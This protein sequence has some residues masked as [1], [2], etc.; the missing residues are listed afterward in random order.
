[1][2]FDDDI[3]DLILLKNSA[4]IA[5]IFE[6]IDGLWL[7]MGTG[8]GRTARSI[9]RFLPKDKKLYTF[10]CFTGLPEDWSIYKK[11]DFAQDAPQLDFD[12]A[13][14]IAGL[15]EDTLPVFVEEHKENIAFLHID[16]DLY[17]STKTVFKYLKDRIV[18]GTIIVFDELHGYIKNESVDD[19]QEARAFLEYT[20]ENN[21]EYEFFSYTPRGNQAACIIKG[22]RRE[23]V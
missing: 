13:E 3:T 19:N 21:I 10:D 15:F 23:N 2:A 6:K 14:I 22:T 1:M 4:M 12:K 5:K 7:E 18:P 17:S 8:S 11:H 20:K 9:I 16:C